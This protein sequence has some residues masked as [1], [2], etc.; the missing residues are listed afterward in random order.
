MAR[1]RR[2]LLATLLVTF[3]AL[4]SLAWLWSYRGLDWLTLSLGRSASVEALSWDGRLAVQFV[5]GPHAPTSVAYR[6]QA[7]GRFEELVAPRVLGFRAI[8]VSDHGVTATG[9]IVPYWYP[10]L[11]GAVM[12]ACVAARPLALHPRFR[13]PPAAE[14]P[15]ATG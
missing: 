3:V 9:V 2:T 1:R 13:A 7:Y 8:R 15:D 10:A 11:V 6:F 4:A 5:R 14:A 12:L